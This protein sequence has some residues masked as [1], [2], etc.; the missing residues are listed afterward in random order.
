MVEVAILV[1][2]RPLAAERSALDHQVDEH[3]PRA[4]LVE[5]ELRFFPHTGAAEGLFIKGAHAGKILHPK[6]QVVQR[7]GGKG[8]GLRARHR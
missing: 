8:A 3:V 6:H 1:M 7:Q 4:K 5:P 2:D